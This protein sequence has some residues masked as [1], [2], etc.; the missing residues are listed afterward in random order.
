MMGHKEKVNFREEADVVY[1]KNLYCYVERIS[2][3]TKKK[4]SRRNRRK[5]KQEL[6]ASSILELPTCSEK[7]NN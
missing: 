1:A 7:T 6:K 5:A 4:M 3:E 2:H